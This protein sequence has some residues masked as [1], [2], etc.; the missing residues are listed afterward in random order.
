MLFE[1][2]SYSIYHIGSPPVLGGSER[3]KKK[4]KQVSVG[5][6]EDYIDHGWVVV[7]T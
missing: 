3:N 2:L 7:R 1:N 5:K 6:T 4:R